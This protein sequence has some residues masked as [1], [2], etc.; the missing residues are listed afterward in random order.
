MVLSVAFAFCHALRIDPSVRSMVMAH[1][2][3]VTSV[4]RLLDNLYTQ[5]LDFH[6]SDTLP[7]AFQPWYQDKSASAQLLSK[8]V[9]TM[10]MYQLA[11]FMHF[12]DAHATPLF[13]SHGGDAATGLLQD[14][15]SFGISST[16]ALAVLNAPRLTHILRSRDSTVTAA[17]AYN[18]LA[19]LQ[20]NVK[21]FG[22]HFETLRDSQ[23]RINIDGDAIQNA[24]FES[25]L[26][27]DTLL[28]V[29]NARSEPEKIDGAD[30]SDGQ[31][32][33]MD[34]DKK[35]IVWLH[36]RGLGSPAFR[37]A[38]VQHDVSDMGALLVCWLVFFVAVSHLR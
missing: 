21:H 11:H 19:R 24:H 8:I 4:L 34:D 1:S 37:K 3:L 23:G 38:L 13:Q 14:L 25:K 31:Y 2:E 27:H 15:I 36:R 17:N 29:E 5:V 16:S 32:H 9:Q 7:A 33:L 22:T 12:C 35:L 28:N 18:I 6:S 30:I 20:L 26:S 10:E